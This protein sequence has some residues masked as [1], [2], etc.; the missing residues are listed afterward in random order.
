M[1]EVLSHVKTEDLKICSI[2][3]HNASMSGVSQNML[4]R[5][6]SSCCFD[7]LHGFLCFSNV[8]R[9][10]KQDWF[11]EHLELLVCHH[12]HNLFIGVSNKQ[13]KSFFLKIFSEK[14]EEK[15]G[16]VR[17]APL[18]YHKSPIFNLQL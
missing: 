8:L 7:F 5:I 2:S 14:K 9:K 13:E 12:P 4:C 10:Q 18:I 15:K 3:S 16:K 17:F 6:A 1:T 11:T